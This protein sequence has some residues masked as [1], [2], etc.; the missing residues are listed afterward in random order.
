MDDRG[1]WIRAVLTDER[2]YGHPVVQL[3]GQQ[4]VRGITEVLF[5]RPVMGTDQD[6]LDRAHWAGYE[7]HH[8]ETA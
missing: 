1:R 8:A 3:E 6:L 7:V 2:G 4:M 5:I